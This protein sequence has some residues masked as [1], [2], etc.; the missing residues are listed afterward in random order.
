M[1][2]FYFV[3]KL[4]DCFFYFFSCMF[5]SCICESPDNCDYLC[6]SISA[7]VQACNSRKVPIKWRTE[8]LCRK[9]NIWPNIW[10]KKYL[11][12]QNLSFVNCSV[13]NQH[14]YS[15]PISILFFMIVALQCDDKSPSYNPCISTCPPPTCDNMPIYLGLTS[16]CSEDICVEGNICTEIL[17]NSLSF[18]QA[19]CLIET[20]ISRVRTS[21]LPRRGNP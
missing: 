13:K 19:K 12:I 2:N 10:I 18:L 3:G 8:T 11:L 5:D 1:W 17:C 4:L 7:Y 15:S 14:H 21:R 20:N 9:E 16:M 6:N